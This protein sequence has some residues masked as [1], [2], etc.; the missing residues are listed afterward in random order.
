MSHE[1]RT[2]LNGILGF[3]RLLDRSTNLSADEKKNLA[4]IQRSGEHLLNLINDV[5]DMSKIEAGRAVLSEK[6]FDMFQLL[7]D[8]ENMFRLQAEEKGLQLI[9]ECDA[10]LPQYVRTDEV[11]LRQ[12]LV[13][14]LGNALKFT[15][16]GRISVRLRRWAAT[17]HTLH[18]Q[19]KV[20]DSG[21]GIAPDELGH[22]FEPFV[23]TESGRKSQQGSGLGLSISRKFVQMMGGDITVE[24]E[25]GRGTVFKFG[26]QAEVAEG[27]E[28]ESAP[29]ARRVIALAPDQP[30]YR[31]LIVDDRESNRLLLLRLLALPGFELREAE[32]GQEA[33]DI[34]QKWAPH[35]IFMDMRIPVMDGYEATKRIKRTPKGQSTA[36]IAVTASAS[37]EERAVVLSAGCDDFVRKPFKEAEIFDVIDQHL[38]VRYVYEDNTDTLEP[39]SSEK[40]MLL[41]LTPEALGALPPELLTGLEQASVEGD[42][43]RA[44]RLTEDIRS[45]DAAVADAL[46]VLVADF[47]YEDIV[48][49]LQKVYWSGT[50]GTKKDEEG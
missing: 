33:L 15:K 46:A 13:N 32:N 26:I 44:F 28:I 48:T 21:A 8:V 19:F 50:C 49:L 27:A 38:G 14:L 29:L 20:E 9:I 47:E 24:S 41:A 34:W 11:K 45:H 10:D 36:I 3:S 25:V 6:E 22:L 37:S 12:V 31:I 23:Q 5:L 42:T 30:C 2:P 16:Q 39:E 4:I 35:L 1:L 40:D 7:D 43:D 17:K 18:L